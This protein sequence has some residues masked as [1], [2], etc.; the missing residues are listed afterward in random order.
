MWAALLIGALVAPSTVPSPPF[1]HHPEPRFTLIESGGGLG[2]DVE[3][4][5]MFLAV[6]HGP[7][8]WLVERNRDERNWCGGKGDGQ[9]VSTRTS[10]VDWIDERTCAPLRQVL[11]QLATVRSKERGSTHPFVSDT[12]LLSLVMFEQG[13]MAAERLSE[14]VGPLADWWQ[15]AQEQLKPCWTK[16]RPR[17]L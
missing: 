10:S 12:P 6:E 3:N 16:D 14:Y 4:T 7:T 17:R 15:S 1:D 8:N 13:Q 11:A 9:C 5:T 2:I